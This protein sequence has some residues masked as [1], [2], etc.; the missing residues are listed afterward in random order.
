MGM[1]RL[2]GVTLVHGASGTGKTTLAATWASAALGEGKKVF[3]VS[4]YEDEKTL[5]SSMAGLGIDLKG[6]AFWE[7]ILLDPPTI[8]EEVIRRTTEEKHDLVVIDSVTPLL[9]R[10]DTRQ[11]LLNA[12]YRLIKGADIDVVMISEADGK[13]PADYI[14]D[15]V[16]SMHIEMKKRGYATRRMCVEKARGVP[17]GYCRPFTIVDGRGLV[18]LDELRVSARQPREMA[19]GTPLDRMLR[20][21][22]GTATLIVGSVGAGKTVLL[23]WLAS[24]LSERYSVLYRA[25]SE[26]PW[27]IKR[28]ADKFG[29]DFPVVKVRWTPLE[30]GGMEYHIYQVLTDYSPDVII[31]D[32]FDVE[33][34]VYGSDALE[35]NMR[36]LFMLKEAGVA[37]VGSLVRD[38]G[39]APYV[40]NVLRLVKAGEKKRQLRAVKVFGDSEAATCDVELGPQLLV[41]C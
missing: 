30:F 31:S 22:G 15:N 27:Q 38:W 24:R 23:T 12:I 14:A 32:G 35:S 41:H 19:T 33:F 16:I 2:S 37:W 25:F 40:D 13:S 26:E 10:A 20:L 34:M 9:E 11:L 29:G 8:L 17:A 28:L 7:A 39:L 4:F 18:F 21:Y 3:W 6:L 36:S 5:V 1:L